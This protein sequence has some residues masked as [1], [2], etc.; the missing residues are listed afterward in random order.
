[1]SKLKL[2]LYWAATC[3]G[4]D[5]AVLDTDE[6]ILDIAAAAD[7]VFWPIATDFKRH[8]VESLEEKAIDVCLFNGGVRSSEHEEMAHLLRAKS[9]VLVAFGSC[10]S[11][12]GIPGLA[13][14]AN[15]EQIFGYAYGRSPS[16]DNQE[17][18]LP[19]PAYNA[20]EGVLTLPEFFDDVRKLDQTVPVD[21][22]VPGCPPA[23]NQIWNVVQAIVSGQLPPVGSVVGAS[24][25]SLCEECPRVKE[26]KKVK[27]FV[28]PHQIRPQPDKCLLEQ[29]ILCSGSATRGGCG[30]RCIKANL[31]CRGCYGPPPGVI[32]QGAKMLSAAASVI[33]A[34]DPAEIARILDE[35]PDPLGYF[36]RFALPS[37]MLRRVRLT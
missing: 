19:Q 32:D 35:I 2:A 24:D 3:G 18:T 7:I 33:D 6:H 22:Y 28:R 5:V 9:K 11:F 27:A 23:A 13:N 30:A 34:E 8:S 26:E 37:S 14:V 21:Y 36:Y 10:A 15:R 12:G 4:C 29:G 20:P 31:P 25:R 17:G 16:T 1:M